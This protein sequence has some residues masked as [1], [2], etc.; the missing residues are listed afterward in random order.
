MKKI[1]ITYIYLL[2][3]LF[4][5]FLLIYPPIK[6]SYYKKC[7][8]EKYGFNYNYQRRLL[9]L[10]IIPSNWTVRS[11]DSC[12]IWSNP[13]GKTGY[14]WKNISFN[15]CKILNELDLFAFGYNYKNKKYTK[16]LEIETLYDEDSKIKEIKYNLQIGSYSNRISRTEADSLLKTLQ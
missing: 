6:S 14:R 2:V 9:G 3:F 7:V 15:G 5:L 11:L 1:T 12:I 10:Y 4:G 16:V 13:S 8:I